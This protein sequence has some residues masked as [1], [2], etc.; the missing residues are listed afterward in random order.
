MFG[1][2]IWMGYV[3]LKI[4][5]R[6]SGYVL[7]MFSI[8]WVYWQYLGGDYLRIVVT[9]RGELSI[10]D[11]DYVAF[12][13]ELPGS[14]YMW[15]VCCKASMYPKDQMRGHIIHQESPR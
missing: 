2:P 4:V 10:V 15:D 3:G 8:V 13:V 7:L 1:G 5:P 9:G 6:R 11:S 12:H 14:R